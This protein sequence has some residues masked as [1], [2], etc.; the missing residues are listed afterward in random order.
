MYTLR[1]IEEKRENEKASF[2]QI[3]KNFEMGTSYTRVERECGGSVFNNLIKDYPE[4]VKSTIRAFLIFGNGET[5]PIS[6]DDNNHHWLYFIM[7]DSGK[8]LERI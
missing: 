7:T 6:Q 8:T 2:E 3:I 4:C 5:Y 1:I